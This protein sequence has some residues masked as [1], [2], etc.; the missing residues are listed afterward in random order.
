M[1]GNKFEELQPLPLTMYGANKEQIVF[2]CFYGGLQM[3]VFMPNVS[4][5]KSYKISP[6]LLT[7]LKDELA[8]IMKSQ[9]G[10]KRYLSQSKYDVDQKKY[11][12]SFALIFQKDDQQVYSMEI[13]SPDTDPVITTFRASGGIS[14]G[15]DPM[16][17]AEKSSN[18]IKTIYEWFDKYVPIL[19]ILTKKKFTGSYNNS[20]S[21]PATNNSQS[22]NVAQ[23][24]FDT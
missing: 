8:L 23:D 16:S 22:T 9:A 2:S 24:I 11:L 1:N 7:A 18:K 14:I 15:S 20:P 19:R 10:T 4:K 12:P 13:R 5:P 17:D 21:K 3:S 6:D